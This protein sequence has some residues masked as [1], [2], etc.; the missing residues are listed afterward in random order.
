MEIG[1]GMRRVLIVRLDS[2][3]DVLL[4]GPAVAVAA[5]SAAVDLLCSSRGRPAA[6]LLPGVERTIVYDAPWILQPP[7]PVTLDGLRGVVGDLA[8]R[9]YDAAA[10]LTSSHQSALPTAMLLRL[11][12][13]P[14]L[15]AVSNDYPGSLLDHRLRGDPDLHEVE[16]ALAV[17]GMLDFEVGDPATH[18]LRV[19]VEP[20]SPV[21]GRVVIH[22]GAAA[23][24]RTLTP[25]RWR[26]AASELTRRGYEVLVTGTRAEAA[27]CATVAGPTG[28]PPILLGPSNLRRLAE[29]IGTAGVVVA[30]N[31]GPSHLAAAMGRPVVVAFPPTVPPNRWRPW[32]VPHVLLGD[33]N[34]PCAGCRSTRCPLVEQICLSGV[35][36]EDV[37]DAVEQLEVARD[38]AGRLEVIG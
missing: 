27:A 33:L 8:P 17:I 16:R 14:R 36:P 1:G 25:T 9:R 34:V 32:G 15:A 35:R 4:A 30:G 38:T 6:D 28:R 37:A 22:P 31:T 29:V 21:A 7:P 26:A 11:A 19:D 3:G 5:A 24:A 18:H 13:V 12:G 20:A 2:V 10:I 23:V